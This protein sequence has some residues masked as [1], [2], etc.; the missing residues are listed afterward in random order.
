MAKASEEKIESEFAEVPPGTAEAAGMLS[1]ALAKTVEA[2]AASG[3]LDDAREA[4]AELIKV[5]KSL[6]WLMR[7]DRHAINRKARA[8]NKD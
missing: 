6:T 7:E 3:C 4:K 1:Q 5:S 8:A 2:F